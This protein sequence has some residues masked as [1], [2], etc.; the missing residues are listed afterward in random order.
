MYTLWYIYN[1]VNEYIVYVHVMYGTQKKTK[2]QRLQRTMW[3][4]STGVQMFRCTSKKR[5][6]YDALYTMICIHKWNEDSWFVI[7]KEFIL[8]F[9][10]CLFFDTFCETMN[11]KS[12][13]QFINE[14]VSIMCAMEYMKT[15]RNTQQIA[16]VQMYYFYS[17]DCSR[18]KVLHMHMLCIQLMGPHQQIFQLAI[19]K[20]LY[21]K[22]SKN[23]KKE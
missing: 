19:I 18:V 21:T 11:S 4:I 12:I 20:F 17:A 6:F 14:Y 1:I 10:F 3:T 13:F 8:S 2:K 15:L 7:D 16:I 23:K 9:F 22:Q 5:L